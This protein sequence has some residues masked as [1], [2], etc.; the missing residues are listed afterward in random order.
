MTHTNPR[1]FRAD[2]TLDWRESADARIC[3]HQWIAHRADNE[4]RC[5]AQLALLGYAPDPQLW[6]ATARWIAD[7]P[8]DSTPARILYDGFFEV[9]CDTD[10]EHQ[11]FHDRVDPD[12]TVLCS[13]CWT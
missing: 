12:H 7:L 3:F 4:L 2:A 6:D 9:W 5:R 11:A 1:H 8:V 10:D 13:G